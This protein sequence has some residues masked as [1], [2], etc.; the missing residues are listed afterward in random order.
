MYMTNRRS[1][2]P[3]SHRLRATIRVQGSWAK[4]SA[5]GAPADILEGCLTVPHPRPEGVEAYRE[6]NWDGLVRLFES[7]GRQFPAGL[8]R[9]VADY[10]AAE[11]GY[12]VRLIG[13]DPDPIDLSRMCRDY[14]PPLGK[15]RE[16]WDHQYEAVLT[17]LSH[18]RGLLESPTGSGKSAVIAAVARY[19]WEERGWRTLVLAPSKGIMHQLYETLQAWYDGDLPV[20]LCGDGQR[21][22]GVVVV[23]TAQTMQGYRPRRR[24]VRKKKHTR[25]HPPDPVLAQI[26]DTFEV[27]WADETHRASA[28][29]WY[30][31]LMDCKAKHRY[32]CSGTPLK[33]EELADTRL[34]AAIGPVVYRVETAPLIA[35]K[36]TAKP[37]I[38]MVSA[39]GASGPHIDDQVERQLRAAHAAGE[40]ASRYALAYQLGV[41]ENEFMHRAAARSCAWMVDHGRRA[42]LLCRRLDHFARLSDLLEETGLPFVAVHGSS[43]KSD[44][45]HA[46][47]ALRE[48]RT[49]VA[50]AT[51]IWD[52]GED[53]AGVGGLVLA[54]GIKSLVTTIQRIGRGMRNDTDDLWVVDLVPE[55][56]KMLLEHACVRAD[57]YERVGYEVRIQET[58]PLPHEQWSDADLL[59]FEAWDAR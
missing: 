49:S 20:G 24:K 40:S 12:E 51:T 23:A 42:L 57:L 34:I 8:T 26:V 32:G 35:A 44:R 15:F 46:K 1:S 41:V 52:E 22:L 13:W 54:E 31:L 45:D 27:V 36:L 17:M 38:L 53:L 18:R 58:W 55:C 29:T 7:D 56:H 21:E 48:G 10:L 11:H 3:G 50:L 43:D 30:Q 5:P 25:V 16:F 4:L 19:L 47:R 59:P 33:D 6:G 39:T 9:R 2:A 28:G 37:K 14:L